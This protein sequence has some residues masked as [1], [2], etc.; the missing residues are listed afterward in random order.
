M[1]KY[2]GKDSAIIDQEVF[3]LPEASEGSDDD[4]DSMLSNSVE[5]KEEEWYDRLILDNFGY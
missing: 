3:L 1:I 4:S 5:A 2:L